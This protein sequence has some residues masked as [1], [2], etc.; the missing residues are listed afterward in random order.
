MGIK[1]ESVEKQKKQTFIPMQFH[2]QEG[3]VISSKKGILQY[4]S[5]SKEY[6]LVKKFRVTGNNY[7]EVIG[8]KEKIDVHIKK[9]VKK[10]EEGEK[11]E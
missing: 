2:V 10:F 3:D 7:T 11:E 9:E 4:S 6:F 5:L 1:K 8:N